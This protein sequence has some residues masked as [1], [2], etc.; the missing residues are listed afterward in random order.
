LDSLKAHN[1]TY[2]V[3]SFVNIARYV[4]ERN[5]V[6]V[7]EMAASDS[8]IT[9]RVTDTLP[10]SLYNYPVT[11]RRPL[12]SSWI[13]A[14]LTQGGKS[15]SVQIVTDNGTKYL[16]FDVVPD[17]GDVVV[18]KSATTGIGSIGN[19]LPSRS[20]LKQNYPNPF[21]PS[22]AISYQ[23]SADSFVTLKLFNVLGCEVTTLVNGRRSAGEY[24]VMW[25][26]KGYPSGIYFCRLWTDS[27][28]E[29]KRLM[30]VR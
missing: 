5:S 18:R 4:K 10:D 12:P 26:A 23:I 6:S 27:G 2:W 8:A 25:D 17:N 1:D 30:L 29:T 15:I 13:S 9:V 11:I 14:S 20:I 21:N 7:K 24:T 3:S 22:T 16:M 28:A 19:S